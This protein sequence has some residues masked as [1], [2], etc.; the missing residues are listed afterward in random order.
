[1]EIRKIE[2]IDCKLDGGQNILPSAFPF[3]SKNEIQEMYSL[4]DG[5][6]IDKIAVDLGLDVDGE[7][8]YTVALDDNLFFA[9]LTKGGEI[10]PNF[11]KGIS[12]SVISS[13]IGALGEMGLGNDKVVVSLAADDGLI[14]SC[15][16]AMLMGFPIKGIIAPFVEDAEGRH[17]CLVDI[18]DENIPDY[19]NN[20]YEDFDVLLGVNDARAC[21]CADIFTNGF[22]DKTLVVGAFGYNE[23]PDVCVFALTGKKKANSDARKWIDFNC[24]LPNLNCENKRKIS[25]IDKKTMKEL[26]KTLNGAKVY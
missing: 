18:I 23:S 16:M 12:P 26:H 7:G 10:I 11:S 20:F 6:R 2:F 22:E 1:M 24:A 17:F 21:L 3:Y 13:I 19:I 15:F 4:D 8:G 14:L 25:E 5:E 9:D